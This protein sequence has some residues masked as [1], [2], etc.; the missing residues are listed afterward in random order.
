MDGQILAMSELSCLRCPAKK[1]EADFELDGRYTPPR[2]KAVCRTC[3]RAHRRARYAITGRAPQ[4]PRVAYFAKRHRAHIEVVSEL[5]QCPCVDCT[6]CFEPPCMEFDHV[7]DGK[8]SNVANMQNCKRQRVAAEV[9]L[10]EV[11]C[12]NCHR[13]RTFKR[14]KPTT[15]KRL[16]AFRAK[17]NVLKA[18]PC[19]D[20]HECFHHAAMDFDHARGEKYKGVSAMWSYSWARVLEEIAKCDL[21]CANC[22]R[23]RTQARL[24]NAA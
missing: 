14:M 3:I 19:A 11:V 12:C 5:K 13:V 22:H 16:L 10:C 17:L 24:Q 20:C 2:R 9:A 18:D 23:L 6:R 21:V 15:N 7:Q 4:G 8:S 1:S